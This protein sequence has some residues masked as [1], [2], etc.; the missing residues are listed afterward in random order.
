VSL[1]GRTNRDGT[2]A[3]AWLPPGTYTLTADLPPNVTTWEDEQ[4]RPASV[5]IP[6]GN[7]NDTVCH[8]SLHVL[9]GGRIT[10]VVDVGSAR[11]LTAFVHAR[12]AAPDV[13]GEYADSS[14]PVDVADG[15]FDVRNLP[16]GDYVLEFATGFGYRDRWFYPG[17][18]SVGE[19]RTVHVDDG[20]PTEITFVAK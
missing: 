16:A 20:K 12:A 14:G 6:V 4:K 13:H 3:W 11:R 1:H 8:A 15:K 9:P 5:T 10:G 17:V 7:G 18:K 19:A 2:Y